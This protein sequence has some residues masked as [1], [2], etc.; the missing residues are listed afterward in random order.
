MRN[1]VNFAR[2]LAGRGC[3]CPS[4]QVICIGVRVMNHSNMQGAAI[5]SSVL[6]MEMA[7]E[8]PTGRMTGVLLVARLCLHEVLGGKT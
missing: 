4:C 2:S 6:Y 1:T 7:S 5:F 8:D 3:S